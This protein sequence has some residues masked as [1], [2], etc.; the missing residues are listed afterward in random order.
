[1]FGQVSVFVQPLH[2]NQSPQIFEL[3]AT[4]R[5]RES[6][7]KTKSGFSHR[8]TQSEVLKMQGM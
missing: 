4:R 2:Q 3:N 8:S 7:P 6:N 1:M 5:L